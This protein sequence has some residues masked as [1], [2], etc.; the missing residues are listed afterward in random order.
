MEPVSVIIPSH[1]RADLL[2]GALASVLGQEYPRFELIVVDDGSTDHTRQVVAAAE[3]H[4]FE[5]GGE[6]GAL[7]YF[8]QPNR[9]PAA[10]RN[11]G[12][13]Q[14][15]YDLLAFLDSDDRFLPGKL[16]RQAAAM[17]ERPEF[18]LSHTE[19]IWWRN[20]CRLNQKRRHRKEGG[21]IFARS[22]ELC[23]VGMSTVMLRRRLLAEIGF[24]DESLPCCEDYDL[25]LRLSARRPVLFVDQPLTEKHGGR[26]D[27][28]SV[29]FRVGMDRFRIAA[30]G[31]LL[32]GGILTLEQAELARRQL[33]RKC[34]IYG[35]GCL[36]HGR[37]AE[38]RKYLALAATHAPK[39]T[40][41]YEPARAALAGET[42]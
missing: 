36:K 33:V 28:V 40:R 39:L 23:V 12:I 24:F 21:D 37:P 8:F 18:L 13:R 32:Q 7:R 14:A 10:A 4:W 16:T 35:Q 11:L 19:E 22:L 42:S 31:K 2:A 30:L 26:P 3:R 9:G 20:G 25:W 6:P 29:R 38:G 15:R 34:L 41:P 5:N 17:A 27:Q 1:N